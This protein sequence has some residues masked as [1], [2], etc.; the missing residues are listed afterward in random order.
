MAFVASI[1]VLAIDTAVLRHISFVV[2]YNYALEIFLVISSQVMD[3]ALAGI[4]CR[5]LVWPSEMVWP[6]N[7][8]YIALLRTLHKPEQSLS[9]RWLH[10]TRLIFFTFATIGQAIYYWLPGYIMPVWSAFLLLYGLGFG[11]FQV[12]WYSL[13]SRLSSPILGPRWAQIDILVGFIFFVWIFI[14]GSIY[15]GNLWNFKI[16]PILNK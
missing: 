1:P 4:V 10:L 6:V 3:Y 9:H 14:P 7:L 12:D 5:F 13:T 16:F 11:S 8:P 15:Y 2:E